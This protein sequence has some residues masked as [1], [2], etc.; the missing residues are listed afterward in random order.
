MTFQEWL[1]TGI[2]NGYCSSP[3]CQHREGIPATKE[4][5]E[6]QI[7][8]PEGVCLWSVRVLADE[9]PAEEAEPTIN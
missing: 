8:D 1:N 2:E 7:A 3:Y 9:Q 5:A 4:E 6:A